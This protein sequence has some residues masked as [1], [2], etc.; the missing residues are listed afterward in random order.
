MVQ[1]A[2]RHHENSITRLDEIAQCEDVSANFL[3]QIMND[4]KNAGVVQS[5]RG[6]SGGYFIK[7]PL[8][9]ITLYDIVA[10]VEPAMLSVMGEQSGDSASEVAGAWSEIS[11]Q[12]DHALKKITLLQ[13]LRS[14]D[15]PMFYI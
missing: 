2:K 4:L 3:V 11:S 15:A 8:E 1:L 14:N 12:L 7:K 9:E 5:K 6:K 13:L 10:A